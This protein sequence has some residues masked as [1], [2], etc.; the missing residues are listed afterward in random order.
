[1]E[2]LFP[3]FVT[4]RICPPAWSG[5]LRKK[6]AK[7]NQRPASRFRNWRTFSLGQ[8]A[9]IKSN[10]NLKTSDGCGVYNPDESSNNN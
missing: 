2:H 8:R 10:Q 6:E 4:G 1:M 5:P 9:E 7:S 3:I